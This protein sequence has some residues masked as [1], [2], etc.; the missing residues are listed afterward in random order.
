MDR[1]VVTE[2]LVKMLGEKDPIGKVF[3]TATGGPMYQI[4]GMIPDF[5]LYDLTTERRP[6]TMH[7]SSSKPINYVLIRVSPQNL[8]NSMH[9][10]QNVWQKH[11]PQAAF[12]GSFLDENLD[13]WYKGEKRLLKIFSVASGIAMLLSCLGLFAIAVLMIE[14]RVKEVGVRK[15]L[16]ASIPS[17]IAVLSKD[18]VKLVLVAL[19]IALPVAWYLTRSWLSSYPYRVEPSVW[20]FAGVGAT[21]LLIT[22]ITVSFQTVKAALTNPVNSLK[23]E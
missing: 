23:S 5:H 1:V 6:I 8:S 11:V 15:V 3:Q 22:L 4:I 16:G 9:K 20:V 10:V 18:F 12:M 21:A 7:L 17:I 19:A 2:S 13:A 14:Q